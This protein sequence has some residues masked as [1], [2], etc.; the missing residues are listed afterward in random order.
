MRIGTKLSLVVVAALSFAPAVH[1]A[2]LE[3]GGMDAALE[4][5]AL[6]AAT[7]VMVAQADA[8][9]AAAV[10]P[11]KLAPRREDGDLIMGAADAPVTIVEYASLTCPHCAAFHTKTLP[12]LK[13]TYIDTGQVKLIYRD[14]PLDR[15]ALAAAMIARCVEPARS[16]AFLDVFFQQ[17]S[18]WAAGSDPNR[19]IAALKRLA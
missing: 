19:M 12:K 8:T 9:P 11:A 2:S 16:F 14:F 6:T 7:P 1:A 10:D 3:S 15:V 18:S 17:Q 4:A 5:T 13:E